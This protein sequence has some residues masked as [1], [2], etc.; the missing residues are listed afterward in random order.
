MFG[1]KVGLL[2]HAR[3]MTIGVDLYTIAVAANLL[4]ALGA[5][6]LFAAFR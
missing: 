3:K 1:A 4:A 2:S 6:M 5:S